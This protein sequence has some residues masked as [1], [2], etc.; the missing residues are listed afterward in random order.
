MKHLDLTHRL[1]VKRL[2]TLA[3]GLAAANDQNPEY[4]RGL[5]E[6]IC[7]ANGLPLDHVA[8]ILTLLR[9]SPPE[10]PNATP[11]S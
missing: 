3:S 6:L 1:T 9:P 10:S 5:A 2:V 11:E 8:E 4:T 7:E